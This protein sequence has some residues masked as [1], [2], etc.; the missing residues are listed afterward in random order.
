MPHPLAYPL[1]GPII[2]TVVSTVVSEGLKSSKTVAVFYLSVA[3]SCYNAT[4]SKRVACAT[5][6]VACGIAFIPGP[7][8]APFI[9]V[10]TVNLE[11]VNKL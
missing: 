7:L 4:G 6:A 2:K 9:A 1:A 5:A 11:V 8:Q 10:C 3:K